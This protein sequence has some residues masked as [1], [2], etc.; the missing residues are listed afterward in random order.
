MSSRLVLPAVVLA[1][2]GLAA[3]A[4]SDEPTPTTS[5]TLSAADSSGG[6][7]A[8][9]GSAAT[10]PTPAPSASP[11]APTSASASIL[12]LRPDGLDLESTSGARLSRLDFGTATA[13]Q[14]DQALGQALGIGTPKREDLP[15]C[16]QGA[17]TSARVDRFS[18][19][20]DGTSFVGWTDQ[21]VKGH[22]LTAANGLGIGSTL[23]QVKAAQP[24]TKTMDDSLGPE[25]FS[26]TGISGML[27]GLKASS[28]VT[29]VY[30]GE[31]CFFR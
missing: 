2:L 24:D 7:I 22:R 30:A 11:S 14:V 8:A 29:L 9:A 1:A 10:A 15:E 17:R 31:T 21:G 12:V 6:S 4:S 13:T 16:G 19:L 18:V 25:F 5:V 20:Y 26:E 3:C 27:D 28:K 23:A